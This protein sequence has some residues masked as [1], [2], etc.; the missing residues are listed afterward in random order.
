MERLN[1]IFADWAKDDKKTELASERVELANAQELLRYAKGV[2]VFG[3]NIDISEE[4]L[5]KAF[6]AL[7]V[8][9]ADLQKDLNLLK[10]GIETVDKLAKDLGLNANQI[11]NYKESKDALKFGESQIKK[12]KKYI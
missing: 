5:E 11:P 8:D 6:R 3:K 12:A 4:Q 7:K 1:K 2:R 9:L 10:K